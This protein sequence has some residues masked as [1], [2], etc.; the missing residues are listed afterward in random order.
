MD[1]FT[2]GGDNQRKIELFLLVVYTCYCSN[3]IFL[4]VENV[5][6]TWVSLG[7]MCCWAFC[8]IVTLA[9]FKSYE[10]RTLFV[11]SVIQISLVIYA[12]QLDGV[13]RILPIFITFVVITGLFGI[14]KNIYVTVISATFI[15]CYHG[16]VLKTFNIE[17]FGDS[18]SALVQLLNVYLVE[19]LVFMW[20]KR[21]REGS[22]K[23][24]G[25]IDKLKE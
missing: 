24:L 8:C 10:F 23:L 4:S 6:G 5:W 21:N 20:T 2:Y 19:F 13:M 18:I 9:K 3:M 1:K 25:T 12:M 15:F 16:F 17:T 22:E 14:E 7:L 11:T